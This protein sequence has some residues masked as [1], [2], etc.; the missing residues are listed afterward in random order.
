MHLRT[1]LLVVVVISTMN[2]EGWSQEPGGPGPLRRLPTDQV[3]TIVSAGTDIMI[4]PAAIERFLEEL[5]GHPPD[6]AAIYG[7]G[8]HD[9]GHDDRLFTLNRERDAK[10]EGRAALSTRIA[11]V[12]TGSLSRYDAV[13]GGFP[14]ALGPNII[15]TS[16]G[17]VRFK[18]EEVP[19]N[20]SVVTDASD[21]VRFE[22]LL[23]KGEPVEID[24]LMTGRLVPEESIVYDFSHDEEG[25]G[26]IM[27]FVRIEQIAFLKSTPDGQGR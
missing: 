23:A 1:L 24:V 6:W 21:R 14:V 5:D 25:L 3:E 17:M 18:P 7:G 12:W 8:H 9:P 16:W 2:V 19:G 10:R 20:L 13:T 15:K 11:F 27:P 4:Q 26:L 22:R